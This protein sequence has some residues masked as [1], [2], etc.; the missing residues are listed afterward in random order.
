MIELNNHLLTFQF[1]EVHSEAKCSIHFQRTLRLP[2]D[3]RVYPLPPGLGCFPLTHVDDLEDLIPEAWHQHGGI[4]F[5]M[6]QSEAMWIC[7]DTSY[8]FAIK[9]AAGK[10]N[11]VTGGAWS[12]TLQQDPQDYL[13]IPEQPWLDGFAI[14]KGK[15]RQF[16]AMP[17]GK[18]YTAEEQITGKAEHGGVQIIVYPMKKEAYQKIV[19]ERREPR[20]AGMFAGVSEYDRC[21]QGLD[22]DMGLA[23]GGVMRQEIYEDFYGIDSWEPAAFSR[24][25]VHIA[26]S[27]QYAKLTGNFPPTMPP[28]AKDYT[29][30]GLPWFDYYSDNLKALSGS[31]TLSQ[32]D[33]VAAK[34]M[35]KDEA[36]LSEN[37]PVA[38]GHVVKLGTVKVREGE[39]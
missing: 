24:C 22:F 9:V 15:I 10:I 38:P 39:F 4:F 34:G 29:E 7:F 5:P 37:D 20:T 32:L 35:K 26:N 17:L 12:N 23:P 27:K 1:P 6:Y 2:D 3:N 25:Y 11:A 13:V 28:T 8:P 36:P 14:S 16:V 19:A 18:G 31:Q 21:S 33:S 30:A